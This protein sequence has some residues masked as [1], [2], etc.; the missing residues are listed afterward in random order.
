MTS[1]AHP[2][3][4]VTGATG[5]LG[6]LVIGALLQNI[7]ATR[8]VAGVRRTDSD[9]ARGLAALG[10]ELRIADYSRPETLASAFLGVDRLLLISSS[11]V[12]Q[13]TAQ[14][15]NVIAAA[16]RAGVGLL[17]Y[18]SVLRADVS[19]LALAQEHRETEA[20][21]RASGTP[22]ALL[23]NGWYTENYA[24]SIAPA[25]AHGVF[26]GAAGDGRIAS[27]ARADY[28]EAAAAVL[29]GADQAGRIYELAG[30]EAYTL[31]EFAAVISDVSGR[32]IAYQNLPEA[33]FATALVG[34]GL[35]EAFAALLADS[36]AGAAKGALFDNGLQLSALIG[37][38]T[39]PYAVTITQTFATLAAA[40][41]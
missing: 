38:P 10:L 40:H 13:R 36:D 3:I 24:A 31:G 16:T 22:F 37:R 34:A 30:D 32:K 25:L 2:R 8:I 11:E 19:P 6:R 17:A 26:I 14:H 4:F 41:K 33:D 18:T 29:T 20:L 9:V 35:P 28:A 5:Q 15:G 39:T 7:P 23:R 21:L 27:A 1:P 12:G